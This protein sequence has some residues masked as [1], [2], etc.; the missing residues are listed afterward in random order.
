M[1]LEGLKSIFHILTNEYDYHRKTNL[2]S[3]GQLLLKQVHLDDAEKYYLRL[4]NEFSDQSENIIQCHNTLGNLTKNKGDYELSIQWFKKAI[5]INTIENQN[6]I[7]NY[8]IIGDL[9]IK[10]DD[11][12]RAI[13]YYNKTLILLIKIFSE[14]HP[15]LVVCLN[16]IAIAYKNEKKYHK[17]LEY[18]EKALTILEKHPLIHQS[19]IAILHNYIGIIQRHLGYFN[20]ALEHYQYAL[21]ICKYSFSSSYIDIAKTLKNMSIVYEDKN[22]LGQSL[23]CLKKAAT[24]YQ[25]ILSPIHPDMT[26]IEEKIQYILVQ[27]K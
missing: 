20:L 26:E 12:K 6:L 23:L 5:Q 8:N 25:D 7:E 2:F 9:Y 22:E 10:I 11:P 18:H 16:N 3:F 14:D 21:E 24:I 1:F 19:D 27:L 4:L 15:E 17:A 13:E